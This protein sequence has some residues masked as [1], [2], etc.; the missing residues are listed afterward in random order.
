MYDKNKDLEDGREPSFTTA[1]YEMFVQLTYVFVYQGLSESPRVN[2]AQ[3]EFLE[4][5]P[6]PWTWI[7]SFDSFSIYE[8]LPEITELWIGNE[9]VASKAKNRN[10]APPEK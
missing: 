10:P 5:Y 9:K 2:D 1:D 4:Q 6:D 7:D 8:I 3:R